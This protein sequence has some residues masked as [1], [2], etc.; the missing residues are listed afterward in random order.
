[1][2]GAEGLIRELR[3]ALA[4]H[5]SVEVERTSECFGACHRAPIARVGDRYYEDLTADRR[6]QLILELQRQ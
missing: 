6:Q 3:A 1:V 4:D 5:P 2:R